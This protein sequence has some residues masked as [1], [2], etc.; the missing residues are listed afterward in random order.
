MICQLTININHISLKLMN[1]IIIIYPT[2]CLDD[3]L[4]TAGIIKVLAYHPMH[5]YSEHVM[6]T[7]GDI[8]L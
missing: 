7:V 3:H 2:T 5:L 4:K 1:R 6:P 8:L